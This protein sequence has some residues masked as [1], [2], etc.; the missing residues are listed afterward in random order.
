[1]SFYRSVLAAIAAMTLVAP[2]F[3]DDTTTTTGTTTGTT[4]EQTASTGD[5]ATT[6]TTTTT[7]EQAKVDVNKATA[8][9]LMKVK[10][11]SSSRAKAIISYRKKNGDFKSLDDLTKVSGF[12]NINTKTLKGIQDQ[13]SVE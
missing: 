6:T 13:L 3:A 8:K 9:E 1:M 10:G 11:I 4:T 12:K 2:V 7:T 5:N